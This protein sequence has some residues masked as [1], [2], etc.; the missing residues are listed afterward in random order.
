[1][2]NGTLGGAVVIVI[3]DHNNPD[4]YSLHSCQLVLKS[5]TKFAL[6][7]MESHGSHMVSHGSLTA[8]SSY[9]YMYVVEPLVSVNGTMAL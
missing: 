7:C 4:T 3:Y 6:A 5:S 2:N 9:M 1:M 8:C